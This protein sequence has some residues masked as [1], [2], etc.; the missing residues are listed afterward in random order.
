MT[1]SIKLQISYVD[2][3]LFWFFSRMV[4]Q[5]YPLLVVLVSS[6]RIMVQVAILKLV[7][8][9]KSPGMKRPTLLRLAFSLY[10]LHFN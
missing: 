8:V 3:V 6:L 2:V 5:C 1:Y 9:T 7:V 10:F 4:E